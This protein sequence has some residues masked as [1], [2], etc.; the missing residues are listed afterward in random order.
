MYVI[1][2]TVRRVIVDDHG[3]S[4]NQLVPDS[5]KKQRSPLM[6]KP[7]AATSVAMRTLLSNSKVPKGGP[8][9]RPR[10]EARGSDVS[11]DLNCCRASSRCCWSCVRAVTP[12][13]RHAFGFPP[14]L[15][16]VHRIRRDA[17]LP[18]HP[19]QHLSSAN[20]ISLLRKPTKSKC[21]MAFHGPRALVPLWPPASHCFFMATKTRIRWPG[22]PYSCS[23]STRAASLSSEEFSIHTC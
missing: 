13:R 8:E 16:A 7:R 9:R 20:P 17:V 14:G 12:S 21:P 19:H 23:A 2:R 1:F 11:P 15:V 5:N 6:S 4:S 18:E 10:K 3:D 22:P